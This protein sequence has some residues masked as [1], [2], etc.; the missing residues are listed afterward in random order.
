MMKYPEIMSKS[1][2][3]YLDKATALAELSDNK[4]RHGAVIRKNGKTISVG[5]NHTINDPSMLDDAT[6]ATNAAVHAEVAALNACR[7]TNLKGA[8]IYVAR[9][10]KKGEPR[11]SKPC[12]RCQAALRERGVKKIFYTLEHSITF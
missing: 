8:T 9:I 5:I 7:K 10:S 3:Y 11:M 2:R 1:D 6:A 4:F 12:L